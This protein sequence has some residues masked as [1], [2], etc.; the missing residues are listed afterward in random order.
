M[1]VIYSDR[2]LMIPTYFLAPPPSV[3]NHGNAPPPQVTS[4]E[5]SLTKYKGA[6][7][8]TKDKIQQLQ[9]EKV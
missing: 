8:L 6:L 3:R 5:T 7:K 9:T 4:L 1:I 2:E